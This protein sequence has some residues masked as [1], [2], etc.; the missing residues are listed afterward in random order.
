M[1]FSY[2]HNPRYPHCRFEFFAAFENLPSTVTCLVPVSRRF[3]AA[4][5]LSAGGDPVPALNVAIRTYY[6]IS[7][8]ILGHLQD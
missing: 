4:S 7:Y 6:E 1:T 5:I 3:P 2:P 8:Y